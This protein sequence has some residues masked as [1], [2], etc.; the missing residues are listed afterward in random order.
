MNILGI[1]GLLGGNVFQKVSLILA[2]A[3]GL[4][5]N[6]DANKEGNDDLAAGALLALSAGFAA[7]AQKGYNQHGNIVDALISGLTEYKEKMKEL[8]IIKPASPVP[9]R[10]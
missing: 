5:A 3:A 4:L 9:Q 8:G 10:E 2:T 1:F 7:Y 6:L